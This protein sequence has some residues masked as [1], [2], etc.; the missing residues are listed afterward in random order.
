MP[1]F[2]RRH[3]HRF[4]YRHESRSHSH[5]HLKSGS[6]DGCHAGGRRADHGDGHTA[7]D[8]AFRAS[9]VLLF[10][11]VILVMIAVA[12]HAIPPRSEYPLRAPAE[13]R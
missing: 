8:R 10:G 4:A 11:S 1:Y 13:G 3:L 6:G 9:A 2:L 7:S 12:H 5:R